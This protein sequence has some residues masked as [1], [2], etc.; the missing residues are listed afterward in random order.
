MDFVAD[1]LFDGRKIRG[2]VSYHPMI[3]LMPERDLNFF[4]KNIAAD[5]DKNIAS[6][7]AHDEFIKKYCAAM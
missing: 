3:D 5:V 1:Q 2:T 7:L 4:L 6:L